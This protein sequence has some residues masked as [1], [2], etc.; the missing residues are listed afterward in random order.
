MNQGE[1]E[2]AANLVAKALAWMMVLLVAALVIFLVG[3]KTASPPCKPC[4]TLAPPVTITITKFIPCTPRPVDPAK[5]LLAYLDSKSDTIQV[6]LAAGNS[7]TA[8]R[9]REIRELREALKTCTDGDLG[10]NR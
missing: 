8:E 2:W 3:C 10:E 1:T 7:D 6:L 9:E 4:P 5:V